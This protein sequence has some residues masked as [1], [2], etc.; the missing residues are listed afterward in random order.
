MREAFHS[1]LDAIDADL[2]AMC[3][4]VERALI[5]ASAALLEGDGELAERVIAADAQLDALQLDVDERIVD[6][7]ARQSPV[8]GDLRL[9]V[10]A[11]RMSTTLERMGDLAEHVAIVARHGVAQA[12]AGLPQADREDLAAMAEL[13]GQAVRDAREVMRTRDLELAARIEARDADVDALMQ[14]IYDRLADAGAQLTAAQVS[15][16]T[17]L[18]RFYERIGDHAVSLVRRVGFAV[19]G[20][21]PGA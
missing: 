15:D 16:L 3:A 1:D 9:L 2:L 13:T 12:G 8:A 14:R 6:L 11:L 10:S 5:D 17:L 21:Q 4:M 7:L 19:T 18:G 20:G